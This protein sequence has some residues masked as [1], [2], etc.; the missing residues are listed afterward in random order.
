MRNALIPIG[1]LLI[2]V[3]V[4]AANLRI[5]GDR[6]W[7]EAEGAPLPKVLRLFEQRGVEVLIDPSLELGRISGQWENTKVDRLIAQ[8][9][10]P[11]SYLIKWKRVS[12]PLGSFDQLA[13]IQIFSDGN[14]SAAK[15]I[16][17]KRVLDI[18]EG[19]GGIKYLRGEMMVGF[20]EGSSIEDLNAL[21]EKLGGTVVEV[22]DP[23]GIYRIKLNDEMPVE[24]AMEIANAHEGV[25]SSEPNLAYPKIDSPKMPMNGSGEGMNLQ[26]RPGET[27]VAV[28]D[29]GLDPQYATLATIRGTYDALNPGAE[30]SDP[31]GHGTLTSLIAAGVI[32]P[33]GAA[34]TDT[35]TPVLS[36]RTFDEN[37]N[38]S[39]DTVFRAINYAV[40]SGVEII[41]MSWG[42]EIDSKFLATAM[43]YA[44]QNG[45]RLYASA[46]NEPT[47]QPIYPAGYPSVT[48]VGGLNPDGSRWESSNYG[49]F[50]LIYAPAKASFNGQDYAGTSIS[51]PY[52]AGKDARNT[53]P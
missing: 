3:F 10:G 20:R 41:S 6:A 28:L 22:I 40:N 44:A 9:A 23:P 2:P 26:L 39:A 30:I 33:D 47:G 37:G 15:P 43:A 53:T 42:T 38:T 25:D 21:L 50:V 13:S 45:V 31:T 16:T 35:G 29:S 34:A 17:E 27:A 4:S 19:E 8:L 32:T 12:G 11:H 51:T 7:L 24:K 1:L 36:I 14:A 48:A 18:V 49:E 5:E 52:V 46:G